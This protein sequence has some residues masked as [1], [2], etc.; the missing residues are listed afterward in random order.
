LRQE[1]PV[2]DQ[3]VGRTSSKRGAKA[4][5]APAIASENI[6]QLLPGAVVP[7]RAQLSAYWKKV[8]PRALDY[9]GRRPLRL[10]RHVGG[11]TF[12]HQGPLPPVPEAV[13]RLRIEKRDGG[14]GT[15]LW[16]DSLDGLLGLLEIDVV[17]LHPWGATVDDIERPDTL[18][19]ALEPGDGVD[20]KSVA[21]TA[22]QMR[23][24][25][26]AED[27]DSW[28]KLTGS[29]VHVMVPVEP[30][31]DW[32][33]AHQ[34]SREIAERLAATAPDR[35]VTTAARDKRQGRLLIDWQRNSRGNTA[36]GAY[37]PRALAGFP[38]AAPIGWRELEKGIRPDAFTIVRPGSLRRARA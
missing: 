16:V 27:L 22:L 33:E 18:A 6:Q 5:P 7:S 24:L 19:F 21:E 34:Y 28:P 8:A 30:D 3:A 23:E 12:F 36:L 20:W 1:L 2:L 17:E 37:S 10:V 11:T 9:L 31:L 13:H 25:L 15:R 32:N 35:Y 4:E 29:G 14:E 26:S 38:I